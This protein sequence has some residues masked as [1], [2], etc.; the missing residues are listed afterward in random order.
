VDVLPVEVHVAE[1]ERDS[2]G[3]AEPARVDELQQRRVAERERP[4]TAGGCVDSLLDLLERRCL[5]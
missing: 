3:G 4:V 5:R 1:V 2:L